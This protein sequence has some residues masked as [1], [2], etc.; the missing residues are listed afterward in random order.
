MKTV[1]LYH[2][3]SCSNKTYDVVDCV[4]EM[5]QELQNAYESGTLKQFNEPKINLLKDDRNF[6]FFRL[7]ST[8]RLIETLDSMPDADY[9]AKF[10]QSLPKER[11]LKIVPAGQ[12]TQTQSEDG[13]EYACVVSTFAN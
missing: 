8:Q 5:L 10:I 3:A 12:H 11:L 4:R 6:S 2:S 13:P 9:L 7:R 1:A